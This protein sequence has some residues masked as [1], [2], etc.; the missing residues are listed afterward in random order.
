MVTE[1]DGVVEDFLKIGSSEI[2]TYKLWVDIRCFRRKE[3]KVV[4]GVRPGENIGRVS[5]L[6]I[7]YMLQDR[8]ICEGLNSLKT[9]TLG[10]NMV[11]IKPLQGEVLEELFK[12]SS[13]LM[14]TYF[15]EV[16]KWNQTVVAHDRLVQLRIKWVP[17]YAWTVRF[18]KLMLVKDGPIIRGV[19]RN[20]LSSHMISSREGDVQDNPIEGHKFGNRK[21]GARESGCWLHID[22]FTRLNGY[23]EEPNNIK[24]GSGE[25]GLLEGLEEEVREIECLVEVEVEYAVEKGNILVEKM[26]KHRGRP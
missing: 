8:L 18:F 6:V 1:S 5:D 10:G 13:A 24:V 4:K 23:W 19:G 3:I 15:Y 21:S 26:I 14:S 7:I 9:I 16:S 25:K 17:M 11:L 12:E 2:G 20:G 22:A